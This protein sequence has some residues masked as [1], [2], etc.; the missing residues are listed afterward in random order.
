[1]ARQA[2]AERAWASISRFYENVKKRMR[3]GRVPR[4]CKRTK[5]ELKVRKSGFPSFR[6]IAARLS[7]KPTRG[8]LHSIENQLLLPIN[9]GL[10]D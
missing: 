2:S 1:M 5:Q 3:C 4:P 6:K 10:A 7:I 9:A 8:N